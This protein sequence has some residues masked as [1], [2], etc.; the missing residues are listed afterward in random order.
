M[1]HIIIEHSKEVS[2]VV[3]VKELSKALHQTLSKQDTV[4][5]NS[6]KTRSI[7][8]D[9]ALVGDGTNNHFIHI[10]VLLLSGRSEKLKEKM[11]FN[12]HETAKNTLGTFACSLSINIDELGTYKK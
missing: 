2:K 7:E 12:L 1:P 10:Q 5:L 8:C 11:A 4:S 9:N 6:I 3:N